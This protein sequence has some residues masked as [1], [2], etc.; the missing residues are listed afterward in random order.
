MQPKKRCDNEILTLDKRSE[1]LKSSR[2]E[3]GSVCQ[4][5]KL[6]LNQRRFSFRFVKQTQPFY[7]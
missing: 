2:L 6:K 4:T 1:I 7:K 5:S 3:F